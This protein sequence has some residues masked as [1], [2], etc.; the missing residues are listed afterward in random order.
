LAA[1]VD[2]NV[3]TIVTK[4][5]EKYREQQYGYERLNNRIKRLPKYLQ[6]EKQKDY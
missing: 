2:E 4:E 5:I 6:V 3:Y 1:V